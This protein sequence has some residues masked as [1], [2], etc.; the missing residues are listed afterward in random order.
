MSEPM[1]RLGAEV[2]G[3]DASLK[4]IK[5]ARTHSEK[6]NLRLIIL[7]HHLKN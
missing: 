6:I 4:N 7:I 3:I 2:T 1:C 5:I